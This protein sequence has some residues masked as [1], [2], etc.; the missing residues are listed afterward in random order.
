MGAPRTAVE[1]PDGKRRYVRIHEG[2]PREYFNVT[3]ATSLWGDHPW[4]I[5]YGSKTAAE[6]AVESYESGKFKA[7]YDA[8]RDMLLKYVKG[9]ARRDRD[10]AGNRGTQV[11]DAWEFYLKVGRAPEIADPLVQTMFQRLLDL[12]KKYEVVWERSEQTVFNDTDLWAGTMD[13][14]VTLRFPGETERRRCVADIKT[15]RSVNKPPKYEYVLQIAA[16]RHGEVIAHEGGDWEPM[17]ET[18]ELGVIFHVRPDSSAVI[19]CLAD[20]IAYDDF[21]VC[22]DMVKA[23]RRLKDRVM[24]LPVLGDPD[25][26]TSALTGNKEKIK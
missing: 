4:A 13:A 18:D 9:A 26:D 6:C 2:H 10:E 22:L 12:T 24:Y 25:D 1:K 8:D 17:P 15:S 3:G 20:E 16:L 23:E 19:P 5:P 7:L 21:L 11:H 14:I